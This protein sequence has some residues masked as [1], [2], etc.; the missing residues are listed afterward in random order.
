MFRR[1]VLPPSSGQGYT[2]QSM[3]KE[4]I[5]VPE[6]GGSRFLEKVGALPNYMVLHP[7]RE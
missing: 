5:S 6:D 2:K 4:A 7:R 1:H 3:N